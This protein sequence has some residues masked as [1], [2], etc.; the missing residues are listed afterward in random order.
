MHKQTI[1]LHTQ[2]AYYI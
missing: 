2:R 1:W